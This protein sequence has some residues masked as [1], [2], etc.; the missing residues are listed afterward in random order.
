MA[1]FAKCVKGAAFTYQNYFN[2]LIFTG[3][4]FVEHYCIL[5]QIESAAKVLPYVNLIEK[6]KS[7]TADRCGT[8]GC[9]CHV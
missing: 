4:M 2:C 7:I 6:N 9:I 8:T 5:F 3:K 1:G